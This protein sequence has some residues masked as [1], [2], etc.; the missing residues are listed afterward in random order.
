MKPT[1]ETNFCR[2]FE[3]PDSYPEGFCFNGGFPVEFKCVDWFNPWPR[4]DYKLVDATWE[5]VSKKLR[6]WLSE[7]CYVKPGKVYLLITDFN[8]SMIFGHKLTKF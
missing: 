5:E 4:E 1:E 7:K 6:P 2:V 3:L 8:E